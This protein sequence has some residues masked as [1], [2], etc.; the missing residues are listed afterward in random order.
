MKAIGGY[1]ALELSRGEEYHK[2]ALRLNTGRN[3]L[4]MILRVRKYSKVYL[5]FYVCDVLFEPLRKLNIPADFYAID[6]N[7]E[8]VFDYASVGKT[9]GFLYVNYF[10]L[11]DVFINEL[12]DLCKNLIIDNSQAFFSCPLRGIDTFYSCRKFFGVPDGAY[13][14]ISS[15]HAVDA[16]EDSSFDR[17]AH[18]LKR[19]DGGAESGYADFKKNEMKL[20]KQPVLQMSRLTKALLGGID[21]ESTRAARRNN[22]VFLHKKLQRFNELGFS[23]DDIAAPMVY[24]FLSRLSGLRSALIGKKIFVAQYWPNVGEWQP[25]KNSFE[26]YCSENLCPLPINQGLSQED[27]SFIAEQVLKIIQRGQT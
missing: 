19:I 9:E 18:L 20:A 16:H 5:P 2:N 23:A 10:G 25:D 12:P 4:E 24:P 6:K 11:K 7:F 22:F 3:A 8:P 27:M 13:A 1:L 14:Y 21:Y 15:A 26:M 17:M